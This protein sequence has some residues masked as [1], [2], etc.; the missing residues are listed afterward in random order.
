MGQAAADR[1][2]VA[3]G[4]EWLVD[5]HGC[6][7][8]LLRSV[9]AIGALFGRI[10]EAL[11]LHPLG[12]PVWYSFPDGGGLTG[13]LLLRESHLACH[14][15]PERRFAAINLY[16]CRPR[17]EW[18]WRVGLAEALGAE[19]VIVRLVTRGEAADGPAD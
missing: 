9:D 15:F 5:A 6:Q 2:S 8:D 1:I 4:T 11:D 19:Q 13:I 17:T 14:T 3:L 12:E 7:P 10:V 16:C 18:A